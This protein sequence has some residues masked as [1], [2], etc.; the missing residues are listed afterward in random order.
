MRYDKNPRLPF[1]FWGLP[2]SS[3]VGVTVQVVG[4]SSLCSIYLP[5]RKKSGSVITELS[6]WIGG[7]WPWFFWSLSQIRVSPRLA[8]LFA[9]RFSAK[10]SARVS[11]LHITSVT[12]F[13]Y[14]FIFMAYQP[15]VRQGFLI[16]EASRSHSDTPHSAGLLWTRNRPVAEISTWQNTTLT[17]DR[18]PSLRWGSKPQ[19]QQARGREPT[20]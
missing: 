17:R 20:S 10:E 18:H 5:L 12:L 2:R 15:L 14:V 16:I 13:C 8:V 6:H 4:M 9:V 1:V 11:V 7:G 19:Y 3:L